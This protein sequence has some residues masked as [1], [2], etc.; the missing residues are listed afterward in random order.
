[1]KRL[2]ELRIGGGYTQEQLAEM[3]KVSQQTIARWETGKA[4]PNIAALRDIAV[5][6]GTSVDHLIEFSKTGRKPSTVH[7]SV[8]GNDEGFWGHLGLLLLDAPNTRW[9]P[10]SLSQ[11]NSIAQYSTHSNSKWLVV[12]TLNN[13][14]L[15]INLSEVKR[16]WVLDDAADQPGDDWVLNWDAYEGYA[17]EIYK[18][19]EDLIVNEEELVSEDNY[20]ATLQEII[21]K[22]A[23]D[24]G[25]D[26]DKARE[27]VCYTHIH[28]TD[29]SSISY[30][31]EPED[32]GAVVFTAELEEK[33]DSLIQMSRVEMQADS[34]FS[35]TTIRLIDIPRH[36]LQD[37]DNEISE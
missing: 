2:R 27:F 12:S 6:F 9:F 35:P 30:E 1:M 8:L 32:L 24:K 21:S 34:Y 31:V 33:F 3:L 17:G 25:L 18:G 20:S 15:I 37:K 36:K 16:L 29:G 13:R 22:I 14:V 4:K 5:I 26:M 11:A 19:I 7:Y 23:V 10:I 28:F